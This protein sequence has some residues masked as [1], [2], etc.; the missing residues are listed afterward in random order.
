MARFL[1]TKYGINFFSDNAAS[2]ICQKYI[3]MLPYTWLSILFSNAQFLP[4]WS[5]NLIANVS[6]WTNQDDCDAQT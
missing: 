2:I 4:Q 6:F 3:I 5:F 1:S